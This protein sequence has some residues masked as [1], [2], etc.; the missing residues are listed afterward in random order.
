MS[1]Q[2]F[3]AGVIATLLASNAAATPISDQSQRAAALGECDLRAAVEPLEYLVMQPQ[4]SP[5]EPALPLYLVRAKSINYRCEALKQP[6]RI[7]KK[8]G[9]FCLL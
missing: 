2:T 9:A 7:W 8:A 4:L 3:W 5:L 1:A 6:M